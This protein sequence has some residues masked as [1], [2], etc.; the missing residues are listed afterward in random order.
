MIFCM[1]FIKPFH[2]AW[3]H[4]LVQLNY[5][6]VYII[7]LKEHLFIEWLSIGKDLLQ[8]SKV[9]KQK[10]TETVLWAV[11]ACVCFDL[12]FSCVV[13]INPLIPSIHIQVLQTDL[14]TFP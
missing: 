9:K 5:D 10:R 14:H 8:K 6:T 2:L 12:M 1:S 4:Y 13:F 3:T 11:F 7:V